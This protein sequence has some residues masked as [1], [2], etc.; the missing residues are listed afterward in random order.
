MNDLKSLAKKFQF[1]EEEV[2]KIRDAKTK[3]EVGDIFFIK[4]NE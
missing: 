4:A 3:Q 2:N 1:T